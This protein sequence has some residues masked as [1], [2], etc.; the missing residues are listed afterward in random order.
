[1][2]FNEKP[3]RDFWSVSEHD[4]LDNNDEIG[5]AEPLN[6]EPGLSSRQR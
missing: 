2:P 3:P 1:M 6:N 4:T 5:A